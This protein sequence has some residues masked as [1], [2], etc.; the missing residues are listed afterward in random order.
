V[1]RLL[2]QDV[3][4][5]VHDLRGARTLDLRAALAR[6][7]ATVREPEIA[8]EMPD[9]LE[10]DPLRAQALYRCVQEGLTNAVRHGQARR[11]RVRVLRT[12]HGLELEVADDG[13][14]AEA[15]TPGAGLRGM[16][17]RIEECGG[18]LVVDSGLGSG[19]R[20]RAVLPEPVESG[21]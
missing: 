7:A 9:P 1:T 2:L 16:R 12:P 17:E 20:L 4:E 19:V 6:L 11:V 3:R 21:A 15:L 5:V 18:T 8:L 14:G 10:V 13:R